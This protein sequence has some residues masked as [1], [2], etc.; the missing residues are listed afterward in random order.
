LWGPCFRRPPG[1]HLATAHPTA[2][3]SGLALA[4]LGDGACDLCHPALIRVLGDTREMPRTRIDPEQAAQVVGCQAT[5]G[6]HR[7]RQ[8][9]SRDEHVHMRADDLLLGRGLLTFGG[10]GHAMTLEDV[11]H[12][13]VADGRPH[14]CQG[15]DEAIVSP[16]SILLGEPYHQCLECGIDGWAAWR[17]AGPRAIECPRHQRVVPGEDRLRLDHAGYCGQGL[18]A[19]LFPKLG[20]CLPL[21]IAEPQATRDLRAQHPVFCDPV[22]VASQPLLVHRSPPRGQAVFPIHRFPTF[23]PVACLASE[24]GA[25]REGKPG[26]EQT[27]AGPATLEKRE[28]GAF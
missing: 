22:V 16:G 23:A 14:V 3:S 1:R 4:T 10:W 25:S 12:G 5:P 21:A 9:V 18:P 26:Q 11:A 6:P 8:E 20:P 19:E 7:S 13:L 17:L 2:R 27:L 24:Y 15:P 28:V